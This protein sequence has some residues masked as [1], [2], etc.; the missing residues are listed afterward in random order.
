MTT[1]T[2]I[3][4]QALAARAARASR[5]LKL[6]ANERRLVILCRLL[7]AGEMNVTQLSAAAGL[8]QSALSQHLAKLREEGLVA[9]RRESQTIW[10]RLADPIAQHVLAALH[11]AF[12][13]EGA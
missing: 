13:D 12:A 6:L 10:Y 8:G 4:A 3:K 9:F 2:K 7:E 11:D 1:L 5:L